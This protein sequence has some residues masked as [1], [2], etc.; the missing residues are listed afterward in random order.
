MCSLK[1]VCEFPLLIQVSFHRI[2]AEIG[3]WLAMGPPETPWLNAMVVGIR[4][5]QAERGTW[6]REQS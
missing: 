3:A 2:P 4:N 1:R 5:D 6:K